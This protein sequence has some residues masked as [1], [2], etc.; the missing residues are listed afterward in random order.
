M[1]DIKGE[2]DFQ[3]FEFEIG[4]ILFYEKDIRPHELLATLIF[5]WTLTICVIAKLFFFSL[6]IT[7][8]DQYKIDNQ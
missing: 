6:Q 2:Q 7:P 1:M 4:S 8:Y 3:K 5:K